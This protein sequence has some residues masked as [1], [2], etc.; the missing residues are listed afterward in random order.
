MVGDFMINASI[1]KLA[2]SGQVKMVTA[3][4]KFDFCFA[5]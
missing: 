3:G 1:N 4:I 5:K 2:I